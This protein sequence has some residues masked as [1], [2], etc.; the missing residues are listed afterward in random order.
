[1]TIAVEKPDYAAIKSRQQA[2]WS[3]GDYAIIETTLQIV[4]E[5][6]CEAVELCAGERVLDVAAGNGNAPFAA[7]RRFAEVTST[8]YVADLLNS[9]KERA[10][11][12]RLTV[13]FRQA[14][15]E[16]LAFADASFDVALSTFGVMFGIAPAFVEIC[17]AGITG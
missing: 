9:A 1:M 3:S 2:T 11:A 10:K 5:S 14:D 15:A 6:L 7:S 13:A 12:E 4:G 8:D 17:S 16:A